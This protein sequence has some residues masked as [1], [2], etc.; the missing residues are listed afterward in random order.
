MSR[1]VRRQQGRVR[2][3]QQE[4]EAVP[5]RVLRKD[6]ATSDKIG[7]HSVRWNKEQWPGG[8]KV[9][10]GDLSPGVVE[11]IEEKAGGFGFPA[12]ITV[13]TFGQEIPSGV[14]TELEWTDEVRSNLMSFDGAEVERPIGG[15]WH[16]HDVQVVWEGV[17]FDSVWKGGGVR[18]RVMADGEEQWPRGS[19]Q[20]TAPSRGLP[21]PA[22]VKESVPTDA[23]AEGVSTLEILQT[24]GEAQTIGRAYASLSLREPLSAEQPDMA[25][26]ESQFP[27][28]FMQGDRRWDTSY[29]DGSWQ[30]LGDIGGMFGTRRSWGPEGGRV[31]AT[32]TASSGPLFQVVDIAA[33][34]V[35]SGWPDGSDWGWHFGRPGNPSWRPDGQ[36]IAVTGH[37][38]P[39]N[40]TIRVID[41]STKAEVSAWQKSYTMPD[42]S[43]SSNPACTWSPDGQRL[44][45][46]PQRLYV[47]HQTGSSVEFES[48]WP[49]V[50]DAFGVSWS[51]DGSKI[52]LLL[53]QHTSNGLRV[54]DVATKQVESGWP[55]VGIGSG[56]RALC[57]SPDMRYLFVAS[58]SG[59]G[60]QPFMFDTATKTNVAGEWDGI[61]ITQTNRHF[62]WASFS[63]DGRLF[64]FVRSGIGNPGTT[65]VDVD[66]GNQVQSL[67]TRDGA[68]AA[69]WAGCSDF[70]SG[71]SK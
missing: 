13:E 58:T 9:R 3:S 5:T 7:T 25:E 15:T 63:P 1:L 48:G 20:N 2:S 50:A 36:L 18:L 65:I 44:A 27:D 42:S 22:W 31:A 55:S 32:R 51:P 29:E 6:A 56:A 23:L 14:W 28:W 46:C 4:S 16:W 41:A 64:A 40:A 34:Q 33:E 71:G 30:Q 26:L 17:G 68:M 60:D 24:S 61:P 43:G 62:S 67:G 57:W 12:T 59:A 66:T 11:L 54:I 45:W 52:A 53:R 35:E 21:V 47:L 38:P 10:Q 8:P 39:G 37:G 19:E 69:D 70:I 49:T